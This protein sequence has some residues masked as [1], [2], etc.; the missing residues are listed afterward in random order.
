MQSKS[1]NHLNDSQH[2]AVMHNEGPALIIA[3]PGSGKTRVIT[4]R[5]AWLVENNTSIHQIAALT[6]TNKAAAEMKTRIFSMLGSTPLKF[7]PNIGTFHSFCAYI[8]RENTELLSVDKNFLIYDNYDQISVIKRALNDLNLD[9]K[10]YKPQM[11]L[12]LI[13]KSKSKLETVEIFSKSITTAFDKNIYQIYKNYQEK[14]IQSNALDFDDLLVNAYFMLSSNEEILL[15]YNNK[16]KY[17]MI[18]E[19]QD[20]NFV[21]YKIAQL[22]SQEHNNIFVVGDPDQSIYSWRNADITNILNFQSDY[23][24]TKVV[25]L[26]QN[27][28]SS[29]NIIDASQSVIS[30][31]QNNYNRKITSADQG[32]GNLIITVEAYDE[33]EEAEKIASEVNKITESE[34]IK[35]SDIAIMYR[36]NA[37]SRAFEQVFSINNIPFQLVGGT[38]FYQRQEIKDLL[39]YIRLI[40]NINDDSSFLRIINTPTRGIGKSTIDKIT[41]HAYVENISCYDAAKSLIDKKSESISISTGPAK[42][43]NNF[44]EIIEKIKSVSTNLPIDELITQII[45]TT[46]YKD[47]LINNLSNPEERFENIEELVSSISNFEPADPQNKINEFL[48]SVSLIND[49][50]SMNEEIEKLTLITLHQS[51][52]LEYDTVFLTGLED[53]TLPHILSF[54]NELEMEEE[55]RLL[56]VGITRAKK[57]LYLTRVFKRGGWGKSEV[58]SPSRFLYDIPSKLVIGH[59]VSK[60]KSNNQKTNRYTEKHENKDI[61]KIIAGDKVNHP[62]FGKGIVISAVNSIDDIELTIAFEE[63]KGIKKFLYTMSGIIKI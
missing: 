56:Y 29:Q 26:N 60:P 63:N 32:T 35:L 38:R 50:D 9:S 62:S 7:L 40:I 16:Y 30:E 57:R 53:G 25:Y 3:G 59:K 12:G 41:Q 46:K 22:L 44:I 14:L 61:P 51:K 5:I 8:L 6:F 55:R 48:E 39:A 31:N 45:Q 17:L 20:T 49:V 18:D 19:F 11:V 52:G 34:E 23:P 43:V 13:S 54:D 33:I 47:Y 37:Q 15:S 10:I 58:K 21:Q 24:G 36:T 27:Y 2:D 42:N 1:L 28:R 4:S